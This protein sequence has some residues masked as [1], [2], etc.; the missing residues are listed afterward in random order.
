MGEIP[1][2]VAHVECK[3]A[4]F[5]IFRA[6]KGVFSISLKAKLDLLAENS[7]S[8]R[9][10]DEQRLLKMLMNNYDVNTRPVYNASHPVN[11]KLGITLNQIFDVD[12]RNQVM[13]TH[14]WLDQEWYDEKLTWDPE[15]YNGLHTLRVPC[16]L[17]W[18][19]DIILYN[20]A[21]DYSGYMS[22]LAMVSDDG[23][24]FWPPIVR[25]RS[26][27]SIDITY[28]PFDDQTCWLKFGSW[29][30]D[31]LQVDVLKREQ[32]LDLSNYVHNGEWELINVKIERNVVFYS[33]C[34]EPYPDVTFTLH[35]SRRTL[36][37]T[38]NVLVPCLMLSCL[39]L[40]GFWMPPEGGEKVTL[41][42]TI[43]LAFSVFMLLIAENMPATSF[44]IPLI[45]AYIIVAMG[46]T[47]TSVVC[48]VLVSHLHYKGKMGDQVP[49]VLLRICNFLD[50]LVKVRRHRMHNNTDSS[51]TSSTCLTDCKTP[52]QDSFNSINFTFRSEA[53]YIDLDRS[54]YA[55]GKNSRRRSKSSNCEQGL[56][57]EEIS[58]K[59][60]TLL[61]RQDRIA[62][63][64]GSYEWH[65]I[66]AIIDRALFWIFIVLTFAI[67]II[68]LLLVP[69]GK[70]VN[71]T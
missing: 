39:T 9:E 18:K 40:L 41:G 52:L 68:M 4:W 25:A 58:Q 42:L 2:T 53:D 43:L 12:E 61:E 57:L 49:G 62:R 26:T 23:H 64:K 54:Q 47:S 7:G 32:P 35:I 1:F 71:L 38:Y 20:S 55:S 17:I 3:W 11:V 27:C 44:Y 24:V 60:N 37:Y 33:C 6:N 22:A 36:Y 45:G 67:T 63:D 46:I 29:A 66:A 16:H 50:R 65:E 8:A 56:Q 59:I 34:P 19:P 13:T 15:L 28:F 69:L 31:G 51:Q 70:T 14:I 48:S 10:T 5:K 30:Y 21:D